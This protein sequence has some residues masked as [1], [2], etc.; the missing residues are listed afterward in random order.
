MNSV[1]E[2]ELIGSLQTF[3]ADVLNKY[4][5]PKEKSS[6]FKAHISKSDNKCEEKEEASSIDEEWVSSP[7]S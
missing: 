6:A 2:N 5:Q 7:C 4:S 3:K 1:T